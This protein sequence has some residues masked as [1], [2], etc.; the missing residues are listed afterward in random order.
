MFY[1][2]TSKWR[3][4]PTIIPT[5]P[6]CS[7]PANHCPIG[8]ADTTVAQDLLVTLEQELLHDILEQ[9]VQQVLHEVLEPQVRQI[10][11]DLL[12]PQVQQVLQNLLE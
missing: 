12:E 11:L 6:I 1:S 3:F 8:I 9:Q 2:E 4:S 10:L 7:L 5:F